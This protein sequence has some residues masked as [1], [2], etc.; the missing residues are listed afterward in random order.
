MGPLRAVACWG[1]LLRWDVGGPQRIAVDGELR[2][3]HGGQTGVKV[4]RG[5]IGAVGPFKSRACWGA[6]LRWDVGGPQRIEVTGEQRDN[7]GAVGPF[8]SRACWGAEV[9]GN[10]GTTTG[11]KRG[12]QCVQ[13]AAAEPLEY[14]FGTTRTTIQRR[15]N[16]RAS[17]FLR[18]ATG[19]A[20]RTA[21]SVCVVWGLHV[22][23]H[24][25]VR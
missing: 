16:G 12:M 3:N 21:A 13:C 2:D 4:A 15:G 19:S 17:L 11:D 10:G 18:T 7:L 25:P 9:T 24:R 1:A 14:D 6:S 22:G 8:K 5:S 23:T 20:G